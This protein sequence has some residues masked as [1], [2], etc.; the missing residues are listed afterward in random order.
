MRTVRLF[1]IFILAIGIFSVSGFAQTATPTK[2]AV[3]N[4]E[5]FYVKDVGI[6]KIA[7]E[8]KKL[9]LEFA[10]SKTQLEAMGEKIT[11]LQNELK[12]MQ[13]N[14]AIPFDQSVYSTKAT[15]YEKLGRE[16]KFKN[17]EYN[18]SVENREAQLMDPIRKDIGLR[19]KDFATQKGF[20]LVLNSASLAQSGALLHL[21]D[22]MD[23]TTAFITYYNGLPTRTASVTN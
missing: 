17:D 22:T 10:P 3:I 1:S 20:D 21:T 7:A 9:E 16:L 6:K 23:I 18:L 14:K 13:E 15:E 2:I 19:I 5:A 12:G 4:T 8:Y 11:K